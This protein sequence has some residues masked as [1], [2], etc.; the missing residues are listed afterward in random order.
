MPKVRPVTSSTLRRRLRCEVDLQIHDRCEGHSSWFGYAL[1]T[2]SKAGKKH[3]TKDTKRDLE[4]SG[5]KHELSQMR[6]LLEMV[7]VMVDPEDVR[8]ALE[9]PRLTPPNDVLLQIADRCVPPDE[10]L[11][12]EE[13]PW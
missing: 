3:I 13:R 1:L 6:K 8:A 12:D 9:L 10:A 11:T 5:L 4:I 7:L 2:T